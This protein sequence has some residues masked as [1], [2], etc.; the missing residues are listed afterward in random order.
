M[1]EREIE[2]RLTPQTDIG[3]CSEVSG[4]LRVSL[5][6]KLRGID[7]LSETARILVLQI[8]VKYVE[9]RESS[10]KYHISYGTIYGSNILIK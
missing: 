1:L 9:L 5:N 10:R 7:D 4:M 3:D 6:T 8:R 2:R